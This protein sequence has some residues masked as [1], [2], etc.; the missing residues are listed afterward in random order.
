ME[1]FT[2]VMNGLVMTLEEDGM[3]MRLA[4]LL[5]EQFCRIVNGG[6]KTSI[7]SYFMR[8]YFCLSVFSSSEVLGK[9]T[10]IRG[11]C[12]GKKREETVKPTC[13]SLLYVKSDFGITDT[14][15][16]SFTVFLAR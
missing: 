10:S 11:K 12:L 5:C 6:A 2:K 9:I 15:N 8:S 7:K 16:K 3:F 13:F 1:V 14:T 4:V